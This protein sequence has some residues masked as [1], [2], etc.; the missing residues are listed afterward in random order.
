MN[1]G[2]IFKSRWDR[3]SL[4]IAE[5]GDDIDGT[6]PLDKFTAKEKNYSIYDFKKPNR[7]TLDQ[8][9][10]LTTMHDKMLRVYKW[11]KFD[12]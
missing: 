12:A 3:C 1:Y 5:Q 2:R 6:N 10:A 7:V 9:K 4:D 11:F 8:L